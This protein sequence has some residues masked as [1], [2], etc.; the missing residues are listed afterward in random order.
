MHHLVGDAK[1]SRKHCR[2]GLDDKG[3]WSVWDLDSRNGVYLKDLRVKRFFPRDGESFTVGRT[4]VTFHAGSLP[5]AR[6]ATPLAT[7]HESLMTPLV[8]PVS[9]HAAP[10]HAATTVKIHKRPLPQPRPRV[11]ADPTEPLVKPFGLAFQRPAPRPLLPESAVALEE[12]PSPT[13]SSRSWI[14]AL[15]GLKSTSH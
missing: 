13:Q 9:D 14:A 4:T 12:K 2:I 5:K 8:G 11:H 7:L 15:F 6:P 1:L 10:A 3:R